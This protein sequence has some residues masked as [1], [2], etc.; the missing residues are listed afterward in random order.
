VNRAW[1]VLCAGTTEEAARYAVI[2]MNAGGGRDSETFYHAAYETAAA[3]SESA[4]RRMA[5]RLS[6]RNGRCQSRLAQAIE[7]SAGDILS[8]AC[9]DRALQTRS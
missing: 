9:V 6:R 8:P 7:Q 3:A 1:V 4:V 2:T 5:W